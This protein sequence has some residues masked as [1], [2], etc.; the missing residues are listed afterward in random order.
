MMKSTTLKVKELLNEF[1]DTIFF[2]MLFFYPSKE[3]KA[4][5]RPFDYKVLKEANLLDRLIFI[6]SGEETLFVD[7]DSNISK[8]STKPIHLDDNLSDL[9]N[10]KEQL[11]SSSF[12]ILITKYCDLAFFYS[13][14]TELLYEVIPDLEI[15]IFQHYKPFLLLQKKY[16]QNHLNELKMYFPECPSTYYIDE[17]FIN[18]FIM[19]TQ[20]HNKDTKK[21]DKKDKSIV[22]TR[23]RKVIS[24]EETLSFLLDTIFNVSI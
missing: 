11:S 14:Y 20:N 3:T 15:P 1:K 10:Y 22:K 12:S 17:D 21:V 13:Y 6:E 9:L 4:Y 8:L 19:V 18:E 23:K 7:F 5:G 24:D 16:Y 2:P